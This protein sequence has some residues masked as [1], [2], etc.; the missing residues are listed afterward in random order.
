[1]IVTTICMQI[2]E[3]YYTIH[4]AFEHTLADGQYLQSSLYTVIIFIIFYQ[5]LWL[6]EFRVRNRP[7][8]MRT[9]ELNALLEFWKTHRLND[10]IFQLMLSCLEFS[11]T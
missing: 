10:S 11:R 5:N 1:M 4:K 6:A 2:E 8:A 7:L 3:I 9:T